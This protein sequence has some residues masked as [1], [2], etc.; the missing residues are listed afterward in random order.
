MGEA[1]GN[2]RLAGK[3]VA[4]TGAARGLGAE[5]A[6]H[7]ARNGARVAVCDIA[8]DQGMQVAA[9]I[10]GAGGE[11]RYIDLDVTDEDAWRSALTDVAAAFGALHVLVNNAGI[12]ARSPFATLAA[13]DW[14]RVIEVNL[15]G[16]FLG[17]KLAA[18]LIRDAGGG[19]IVNVSSVAGFDGHPDCAYGASKWGLRGLTKS[20]ALN[21]AGWN[22]RVNSVH[23][24]MVVT[25][26][27][28]T[29]PP[30]YREAASAAIPLGRPA[31]PEEVARVV[32][33]LASDD[34]AFMTGSEVLV[35]GGLIAAG[36]AHMRRQ[37]QT[38]FAAKQKPS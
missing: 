23:P 37:M 9:N 6:L 1:A 13:A 22:V 31:M 33:F 17:T 18:P 8:R 5:I 3:V 11:A 14:R 25:P 30:G 15:T 10:A 38:I 35:N 34:A 19:S 20:A 7:C 4:V 36:T 21:F 2:G 27:Q 24:S 12:I 16:P 29:A 26:L 32:I 28:D